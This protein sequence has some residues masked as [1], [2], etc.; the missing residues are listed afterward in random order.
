MKR[1]LVKVALCAGALSAL[2]LAC[3]GAAPPPPNTPTPKVQAPPS[4]TK[5]EGTKP[6]APA[7]D[8]F[9]ITGPLQSEAV[10]PIAYDQL[11]AALPAPPAGLAPPPAACAAYTARKKAG[12][13]ACDAAVAGLDAALAE[14]DRGTRD[15]MLV[16]LEAC[17]ELPLGVVRALRIE[18]G[19][20]ACGDALAAPVVGKPGPSPE[21]QHTLVGLAVAARLSRTVAAAPKAAPPFDK[22]R[23]LS[24][25]KG[26]LKSWIAT[27]AK[28]IEDLS[29]QAA[30]LRGYGRAVAAVE[31][32][33]ADLRFVEVV[34]GVPVPD[35][36]ATDAELKGV[37]EAALDQ[38]LEP[39]KVRGR[40]AVLVG[41]RDLATLGV[42]QDRRVS[43]A[44][45]LLGKLY[46]G[47]R[48]DALDGLLLPPLP[49]PQSTDAAHKLA[50]RLSSFY[51]SAIPETKAVVDEDGIA[52]LLSRGF[53]MPL[54]ARLKA[55]KPTASLAT[56]AARGRLDLGR[57]YW[58]ALDFDEAAQSARAAIAMAGAGAP[59]EAQ[60]YLA[61]AI[62]LRG[63][64]VDAAQMMRTPPPD[65]LGIGQVGALDAIASSGAPYAG[66]AAF[67]AAWILRVS[68]P[69]AGARAHWADVAV[70]FRKAEKLLSDAPSKTRA[71]DA[72]READA[73]AAAAGDAK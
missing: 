68:A 33:M 40:D 62:A 9:E 30:H 46:A 27:Q 6:A 36:I 8:P 50:R 45:E 63:G 20:A 32:G 43:L 14:E 55:Q 54:R 15:A 23:V 48:I 10:M 39:R 66:L 4:E 38:M 59:R 53:P 24:F 44:R 64:P 29:L 51:A 58:R 70:R 5:P 69:R 72:A 2:G 71:A 49:T 17:A 47:R 61:L 25:I 35:A 34:R 37:Y 13:L 52:G 7:G 67:D 12:K 1:S 57:A 26:P 22:D 11:S 65:A 28:L 31:A 18:A 41:L 60:L 19:E 3:G 16:D 73:I 21:V 42:V 56:L